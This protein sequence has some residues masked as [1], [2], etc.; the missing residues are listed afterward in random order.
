VK[1]LLLKN[2][3]PN[4]HELLQDQ[5]TNN[6]TIAEELVAPTSILVNLKNNNKLHFGGQIMCT[7]L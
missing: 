5:S 1:D 4:V 3:P 6:A 2:S 7:N